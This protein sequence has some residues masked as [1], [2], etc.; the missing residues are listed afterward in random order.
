[1][2]TS[3]G[4]ILNYIKYKRFLSIL[5]RLQNFIFSTKVSYKRAYNLVKSFFFKNFD[6]PKALLPLHRELS[7]NVSV[8]FSLEW[9]NIMKYLRYICLLRTLLFMINIK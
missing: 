1:M 6:I 2:I 7:I 3:I 9:L 5:C 8:A 4:V